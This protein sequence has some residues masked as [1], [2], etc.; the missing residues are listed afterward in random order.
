[1]EKWLIVLLGDQLSPSM[2]DFADRK[3]DHIMMAEVASEATYVAHHKKK[4][5]YH[6]AAMRHFA[7]ELRADGWTVLY[8]IFLMQQAIRRFK[9]R[10]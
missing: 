8:P 6:F 5:V 10:D 4:I 3:T 2:L 7:E 1:M 9:Q